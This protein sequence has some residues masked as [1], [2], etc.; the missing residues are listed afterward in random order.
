MNYLKSEEREAEVESFMEKR[1]HAA[2][3][4]MGLKVTEGE[5]DQAL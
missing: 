3:S 5:R 1:L 2:P 4:S